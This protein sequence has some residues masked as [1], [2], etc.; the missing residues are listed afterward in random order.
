[1][2]AIFDSHTLPDDDPQKLQPHT[3]L[4]LGKTLVLIGLVFGGC[5]TILL[6]SRGL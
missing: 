3:K 1:M 4:L 5:S 6:S 2:P